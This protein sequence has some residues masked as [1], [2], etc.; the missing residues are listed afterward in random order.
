MESKNDSVMLAFGIIVLVIAVM[1]TAAF[2][3][4]EPGAGGGLLWDVYFDVT[5][6][7]VHTEQGSTNE[8]ESD[9]FTV[10]VSGNFTIMN[11]TFELRWTDDDT[12]NTPVSPNQPD[13]F[14]LTVTDPTGEDMRQVEGSN[15]NN[16]QN[17]MLS[18]TFELSILESNFTVKSAV[19]EEALEEELTL[20]HGFGDWSVIVECVD[21]GDSEDPFT[22]T[23]VDQ[24]NGNDWTLTVDAEYYHIT[25]IE[26]HQTPV[27]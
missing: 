7:T 26:K 6:E 11:L 24:D 3:G 25:K 23:T 20:T 21:A 5:T 22:G 8:G 10:D 17:G 19:S 18:I 12:T 4:E 13:T 9:E 1:G 16:N 27:L 15:P 14:N 2:E